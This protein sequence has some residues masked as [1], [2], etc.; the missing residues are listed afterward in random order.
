M[1]E[2]LDK[3][4]L[5]TLVTN[6]KNKITKDLDARITTTQVAQIGINQTNI[7]A[8]QSTVASGVTFK[9]K[10]DTLPTSFTGY[11]NGDLI[12]VG[13]KEYICFDDNGTKK[14][15]EFGNEAHITKAQADGYYV[16]KNADLASGGTKC[17]ITYDKK[18][19]ITGGADLA[20]IDIPDLP[21]SKITSGYIP[22]ERIESAS[23]WNTKQDALNLAQLKAVNSG[24]TKD[25]VDSSDNLLKYLNA[26]AVTSIKVNSTSYTP[27]NGVVDLGTL[28]TSLADYVPYSGATNNIDLGQHS[29]K[30][31]SSLGSS[32][33][34]LTFQGLEVKES[35]GKTI[36][37]KYC[38]NY[39][40]ITSNNTQRDVYL[41]FTDA[42]ENADVIAL[43]GD[44]PEITAITEAEINNLFK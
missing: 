42:P 38:N 11:V 35:I 41:P 23:K 21:A 18:G 16:A 6:I 22:D 1:A 19:L 2:Y 36:L 13:D 12:L 43:T 44:I 32:Y 34:E 33:A 8:L 14:W 37:T 30:A 26:N 28:I 39:I 17:K 29:L 7:E 27:T 4:G 31:T 15:V 5:I 10:K 24:V 40:T 25:W 9:G 20:V 3:Q